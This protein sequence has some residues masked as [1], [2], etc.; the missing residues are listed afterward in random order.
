MAEGSNEQ[1]RVTQGAISAAIGTQCFFQPA[2]QRDYSPT[3]DFFRVLF[4]FLKHHGFHG[5]EL[6]AELGRDS[7]PSAAAEHPPGGGAFLS[8]SSFAHIVATCSCVLKNLTHPL[9]RSWTRYFRS[10]KTRTSN[11]FAKDLFP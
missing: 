1:R 10:D 5:P 8:S 9:I 4:P 3:T 6:K 11:N 2:M 7:K